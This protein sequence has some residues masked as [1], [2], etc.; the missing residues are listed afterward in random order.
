MLVT[1][2]IT[3]PLLFLSATSNGGD[4]VHNIAAPEKVNVR[5]QELVS[6]M[7]L[8]EKCDYIGAA[9]SFVLRGVDRLGIPEIRMAD[10]PQ[11]IRN[12][13]TSTLYPSGIL[14][15]ATFNRELAERLGH[16]L[17]KDAKAR[18]VAIL[19][20]PGVNIYRAPMN[21]RNFEYFGEDPYLSSE[22]AEHYIEGVQ[23]E[24]VI[25][26]VKHF[27]ANNQEWSRHHASSDVDERTLHEIY[28]PA[29]RKAVEKAHVGAVMDSYNPVFGV[30]ATENAYMNIEVLRNMWGFDGILMSDWT[31][32][33]STSGAVN[34]G[35]DLECPKGVYFTKERIMPLIKSGVISEETI[36]RKVYNILST[37]DRF[38]LLDKPVLDESIEK[39][40]PENAAVALDLAREGVVM[41]ENRNSELPYGKRKEKILVLGPNACVTTTGGGSGFVTPFHTVTIADGIKKQFGEKYVQVLSDEELYVDISSDVHPLGDGGHTGFK[42]EYYDNKTLSGKPVLVRTDA[43]VNFDWGRKSPAEGLPEDGFSVRW[44]GTYTAP[45]AGT[46]RFRLSGDDGYRLFVNDQL[47]AGDWGNHSLSSRTAFQSVEKGQTYRIRFEFYDNISDATARMKIG[48]FNETALNAAVAMAGRIIYCGGFNSDIEGEGFDRPFGLPAEQKSLINRLTDAHSHVTVVLNAGGGVDFNGWS[49]GVEAILYAWYTGQEGGTAIAEIVSGKISPSGKLPISIENKWEDNPVYGSYYDNTPVK[50]QNTPFKRIEYREGIFCGYRG[51]DRSGIAPRYPFGYGLSYTSFKYSG[52]KVE[53]VA[54]DSVLVSFTVTNTGK[55]GAYET[56]QVYVSDKAASV[57]RP[58]KELKGYEKKFIPAGKSVN[59]TVTLGPDAFSF[60]DVKS[61]SFVIEPGEFEILVGPSSADLP[62]KATVLL[63]APEYQVVNIAP[64]TVSIIKNPLNGWVMYM[65]RNWDSDFG[66]AQHYDE[67][68]AAVPGG[69]VRVTDWCGTAYIRTSWA[70]MEPEE[71]K[72]FWNDP[73]SRLNR[74][75]TEVR[76]RGL[77]LAF[78]IVVDG[79]DQ[80]QNTPRYVLDAGAKAF[81][82]KL[83]DKEVYTPYPDDPVFQEKYSKFIKAFA[84]RFDSFDEVDFIDAYGLGK[85]GEAHSMKYLDGKNKIPVYEWITDLYSRSFKEVPLVMNY[86]RVLAEETVNGWEDE[87]NP[88]SEGM[89]ESAISKGYS[90][91]HDAF[92]M[93]GYYKEWEKAFAAK[94]NFKVPIIMEGGWIT[95]AHHRYWIDPSGK[96]HEGHPEEV[97]RGEMEEAEEARVNMMDFRVGNETESWFQNI[98][99]VERFIRHG[100]YRLYPAQVVVPEEARTG[101]TLTLTHTWENMGWGYCPNNI[102]QWNHRFKPSFALIAEDGTVARIFVDTKAEPS[103]WMRNKPMGYSLTVSLEGVAPGNY[104]WAV[105][106]SDTEKGNVPGLNMAVDAAS[107]TRDGWLKV[108]K[109]TIR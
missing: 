3:L 82:S 91:R 50:T 61:R 37:L 81:A 25:A 33:Y 101:E 72:Y 58:V 94:W 96:Y 54:S 49:E 97:R 68:P 56:A 90:L 87:P 60:Y 45:E 34:G 28:F 41:L 52:M 83:G 84:S 13:T 29:F 80:G 74:L 55:V 11:G 23:A 66:K 76:N 36:D 10:G 102:R 51:Y 48:L 27:A 18:G 62:L 8:E 86:H 1:F 88:D 64:D 89:L 47:L 85:W 57:A 103:D 30:H 69:K 108:S 75:L 105:A 104:S 77:R 99:L 95:G 12:N 71:G 17:G 40:N 6:K 107:L 31:S 43:S 24:G 73:D 22:V 2:L 7:T 5:A 109:V 20:G 16:G 79:R 98:D 19:L 42:A 100:G 32:V 70:S 106:I 78:R 63:G 4:N 9:T 14:T 93:T 59:M 44:E 65:G 26:T 92:G 53:R 21:G 39:D 38:G 46:L 35:L 67:F 15:A